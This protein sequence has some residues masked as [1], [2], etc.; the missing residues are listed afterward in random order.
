METKDAINRIVELADARAAIDWPGVQDGIVPALVLADSTKVED[1]ER[2]QDQRRRFRGAFATEAI[3]SFRAYIEPFA[4]AMTGTVPCFIKADE[5]RAV[6]YL[7]M[8]GPSKPGHCQHTASLKLRP[9]AVYAALMAVQ[10]KA[11]GQRELAEFLEDWRPHLA[12]EWPGGTVD[13]TASEVARALRAVRA[14]DIKST[15][16]SGTEV[17]QMSETRSSLAKV[18]ATSVH[19]LPAAFI[20]HCKPYE[21]L[22]P[23]DLAMELHIVT[24]EKPVLKLRLRAA[25]A[26]L[27]AI[28]A[29]FAAVLA[30]ALP[31]NVTP[32]VGTFNPGA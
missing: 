8:G 14:I 15:L 19:Q 26:V 7:D 10:G 23:I 27:E 17:G 18:E 2:F 30:A 20:V 6:V 29:E 31:Y 5:A 16:N 11:L 32:I 4:S 24:G 13:G 3:G 28:A 22:P 9:T 21:E 12:V 1:L 25:G